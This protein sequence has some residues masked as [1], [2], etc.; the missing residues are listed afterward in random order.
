MKFLAVPVATLCLAFLTSCGS[1]GGSSSVIP[2]VS[3][4]STYSAA[5]ISGTYS[6]VLNGFGENSASLG[7]VKADGGGNFTSGSLTQYGNTANPTAV[8]TETFTGT[9]SIQSNASGTATINLTTTY[10][11]G[12]TPSDVCFQSGTYTYGIQAAQ[13]GASFLFVQSGTTGGTSSGTAA[14]Q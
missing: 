14:K 12:I 9:Y 10:T 1:S 5:S 4:Q 7:T 13:Q 2:P 6:I 11:S 8:C 3:A